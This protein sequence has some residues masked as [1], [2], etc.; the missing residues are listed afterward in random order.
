LGP[1]PNLDTVTSTKAR[2]PIRLGALASGGGSNLQAI[3]VNCAAGKI[4]AQVAVVISSIAEA[5]A[6]ERARKAGIPAFFVNRKDFPDKSAFN[7]AIADCLREHQVDLVVLAG[8]LRM[9]GPEILEP[10][11]SRIM[12]I[13]P[14]LLPSFGGK[15]FHGLAVHQAV[16]DSGA[17]VSGCTV[18][19][20]DETYD[21]GPIILQKLVPVLDDDTPATLAA[22]VL[23][24]E[25]MAYS[26]A[27]GLF[28]EGRLKIVGRRVVISS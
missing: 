12:N 14:A 23:E 5:Y 20:V 13:H 1:A 21:T 10:Y 8:Y 28:A 24:Q 26:E 9:L 22:R 11:R 6:L 18:H 15:G 17:K 7:R 2:R 19:F 3:I 27:I 25:H 16:I 4:N